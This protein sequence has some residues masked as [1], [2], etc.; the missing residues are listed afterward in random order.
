MEKEYFRN[1]IGVFDSGLGGLA[2]VMA[3]RNL[4]P[5]ENIVYFGDTARLPY[6]NKDK[7]TIVQYS[8][9][10]V[11]FLLK[12]G[13]KALVIGCGTASSCALFE[14][15]SR[16]K[17][18]IIDAVSAVRNSIVKHSLY[19]KILILGTRATVRSR[20]YYQAV[21]HLPDAEIISIAC[22]LL[23]HL[24]EEGYAKHQ[25]ASLLIK[26]YLGIYQNEKVDLVILGCTHFS[27]LADSIKAAFSSDTD[28][29][30]ASYCCGEELTRLLTKDLLLNRDEKASSYQF[31]VSNDPEQFKNAGSTFLSFPLDYVHLVREEE[32]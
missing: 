25:I 23:V 21:E 15:K 24:V 6:G 31:F 27:I 2:V 13:I 19:K 4:L 5:Y 22:P 32:R 8:I 18:P 29:I 11:A 14:L 20:S 12:K 3:I 1:S 10:N 28:I 26:E 7:E 30:D 17:I 9:E 16:F